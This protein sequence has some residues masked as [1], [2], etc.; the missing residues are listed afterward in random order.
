MGADGIEQVRQRK[1][2][3][4][5]AEQFDLA[6]DLREEGHRLTQAFRSNQTRRDV[7]VTSA[8][9]QELANQAGHLKLTGVR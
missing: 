5:D 9:S 1:E 6:R 7:L 4:L 8:A 2:M 3:A